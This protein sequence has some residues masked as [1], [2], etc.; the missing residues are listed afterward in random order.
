[1]MPT[2][3]ARWKPRIRLKSGERFGVVE[4]V[5]LDQNTPQWTCVC[6]AVA[7]QLYENGLVVCANPRCQRIHEKLTHTGLD[8][9]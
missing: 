6:G 2:A 8:N 9:R 1:M 7:F 3:Q 5:F 4:K